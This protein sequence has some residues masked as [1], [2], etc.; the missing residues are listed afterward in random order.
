MH[1]NQHDHIIVKPLIKLTSNITVSMPKQEN[2][3]RLNGIPACH[4][5][6]RREE[7]VFHLQITLLTPVVV[8]L[9]GKVCVHLCF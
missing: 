6:V 9:D 3:V 2:S 7:C 8:L 1:S 5:H 4:I